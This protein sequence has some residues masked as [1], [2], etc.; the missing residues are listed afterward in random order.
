MPRNAEEI[1]RWK[2]PLELGASRRGVIDGLAKMCGVTTR[3]RRF[4]DRLPTVCR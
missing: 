2:I 4:L 3:M 1:R